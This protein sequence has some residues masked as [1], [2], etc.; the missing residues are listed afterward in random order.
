MCIRD[1][2]QAAL[3]PGSDAIFVSC[4]AVRAAG[5]IDRIEDATGVPA[6]SSNYAAAWAVLRAC[7]DTG[8]AA[9]GQ[10]MRLP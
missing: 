8:V 10:L 3:V 7:G 5:V 2:A 4:T 9:P 6:V 1:R